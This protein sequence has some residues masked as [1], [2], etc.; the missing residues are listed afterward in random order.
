[1]WDV[2]YCPRGYVLGTNWKHERFC[3]MCYPT[4]NDVIKYCEDKTKEDY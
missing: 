1:M 2:V 3:K 4:M